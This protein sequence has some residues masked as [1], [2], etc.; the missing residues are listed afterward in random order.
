V[1]DTDCLIRSEILLMFFKCLGRKIKWGLFG[2]RKKILCSFFI[3][4]VEFLLSDYF[5]AFWDAAL[6][7]A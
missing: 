4:G 2:K 7:S 5:L 1:E 6:L 3:F